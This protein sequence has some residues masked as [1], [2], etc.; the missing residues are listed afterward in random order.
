VN[1]VNAQPFGIEPLSFIALSVLLLAS[2][3]T[4]LK[5][6]RI[7][8][9]LTLPS[10]ILALSLYSF[11]N[12]FEGFIFSLK[13]VAVGIGV[14]LIPYLLGGMGA[15]DAK[16][17]GA[18]GGFL[19]AK[20][21]FGAFLI[22]ALLGGFY[23]LFVAFIYRALFKNCFI[24]FWHRILIFLSTREYLPDPND[25]HIQRPKLCYGL[26]IAL[27]TVSYMLFDYLGYDFIS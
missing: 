27:G 21:V 22:T 6:Q 8:N 26:A 24:N 15:G 3:F 2:V 1:S 12:G 10:M 13:G 5:S 7:P 14:F 18:V 16:L 25:G 17:M 23:A 11:T 4:D 9:F 20:G 19:G